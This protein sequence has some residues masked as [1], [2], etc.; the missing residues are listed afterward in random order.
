MSQCNFL[1]QIASALQ[2]LRKY[3]FIHRDI[4]P[5]NLLLDP[6]PTYMQQHEFMEEIPCY[7]PK[8]WYV[9]KSTNLL[10]IAGSPDQEIIDTGTLFPFLA[11]TSE[12][13]PTR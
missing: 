1:K 5:Q 13:T 6:P 2:Y 3:N 12:R 4:K 8:L 11:T 7:R 9:I 10:A